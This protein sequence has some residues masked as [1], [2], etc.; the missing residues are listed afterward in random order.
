MAAL[1]GRVVMHGLSTGTHLSGGN[2][3]ATPGREVGPPAGDGWSFLGPGPKR[4][5][6]REMAFSYGR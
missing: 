6:H 1:P 5:L 3:L 2:R 4:P